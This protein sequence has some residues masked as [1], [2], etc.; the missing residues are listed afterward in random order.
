MY[1]TEALPE[2]LNPH[3]AIQKTTLRWLLSHDFEFRARKI[4]PPWHKI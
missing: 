4:V 1:A 3:Q 2:P